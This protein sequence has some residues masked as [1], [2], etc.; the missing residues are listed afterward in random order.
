MA[1]TTQ[2]VLKNTEGASKVAR[3]Q[4]VGQWDKTTHSVKLLDCHSRQFF[5]QPLTMMRFD[6]EDYHA[7][8]DRGSYRLYLDPVAT[9]EEYGEEM[10]TF[11]QFYDKYITTT[12]PI[13]SICD[14]IMKGDHLYKVIAMHTSIPGGAIAALEDEAGRPWKL[15]HDDDI[16]PC[17]CNDK[18]EDG[19]IVLVASLTGWKPPAQAYPSPVVK[20]V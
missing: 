17:L 12:L 5:D 13:D 19:S 16:Y 1:T 2:A 11:R 15:V 8:E 6:G 7:T 20:T 10:E 18:Y 14:G 4:A 9:L 3:Q